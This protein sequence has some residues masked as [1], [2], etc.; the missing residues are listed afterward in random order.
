MQVD[1]TA[2]WCVDWIGVCD[3]YTTQAR[4]WLMFLRHRQGQLEIQNAPM[5]R[6]IMS[7]VHNWNAREAEYTNPSERTE[8]AINYMQSLDQRY[9][10]GV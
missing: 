10:F 8:R 6:A 5:P 2:T 4:H 3:T 1:L 7:A 9:T